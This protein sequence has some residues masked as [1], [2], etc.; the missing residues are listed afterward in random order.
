MIPFKSH[1]ANS[2]IVACHD[3]EVLAEGAAGTG[4][5]LTILNKIV[6]AA[7]KYKGMRAA[8]V[9][10]TRTS[11]TQTV[12]QTLE[13]KVLPPKIKL[14]TTR[15][16]YTFPNGSEIVIGG[17]DKPDKI[18]SSEYD[19]IFVNEGT[20]LSVVDYETLLTRLRHG[21]MPYQQIIVDCNPAQKTHWL[22]ERA[23]SQQMTRI[24]TG[25][26]DNPHLWDGSKWTAAGEQY[27]S[28][29]K[30][31]LSGLRYKRYFEGIWATAEGVIYETFDPDIHVVGPFPIPDDWSRYR[32]IDF[33]FSN[34]FV[35]QWWAVD[36]D[37]RMYMYREIYHTQRTVRQ[38]AAQ[39]NELSR[40][41]N[42][43][44][45]V[46][47]HDAE[48]RATLH[49]NGI[50]TIAATKTVTLGIERVQER[51]KVQGDG[52][53]RLYF[54]RDALVELDHSLKVSGKPIKT[55]DEF[56]SYIWKTTA[57]RVKDEPQ[58]SDDH[59]VDALR[60]MV[61]NLAD[62]GPLLLW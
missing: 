46:A 47:D 6:I 4:K 16:S 2:D 55:I 20:E 12:L 27:L 37:G 60:Y 28:I 34:P 42:Y 52:K 17:M 29:L 23:Q 26:K 40:G 31:S 44:Y 56:G 18:L 19:M 24:K 58:K 48:D 39:I 5:T 45:T 13:K 3:L 21:V 1:G 7:M 49:E 59:G 25:H 22:N 38:H 10:K 54:F 11:M 50:P 32:A 8:I 41:E 53:P 15:Q 43:Y 30:N 9:R 62:S 33:G 14:H 51:L 35:C 57:N 61:M 36:P